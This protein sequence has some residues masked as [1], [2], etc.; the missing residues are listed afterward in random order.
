MISSEHS[1]FVHTLPGNIMKVE[2]AFVISPV[3]CGHFETLAWS[4]SSFSLLNVM[5]PR[6]PVM[7]PL[8][9]T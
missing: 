9:S 3:I 7:E 4:V 2:K 1:Y 5:F 8:L 6:G